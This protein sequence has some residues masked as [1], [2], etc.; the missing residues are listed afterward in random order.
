MSQQEFETYLSV[1]SRLL[2][3]APEQREHVAEELRD[4]LET[5]LE[6]LTSQGVPHAE[7]VKLALDEFGDAAGVATSFFSI[8]REQR[9]RWVM[10]MTTISVGAA[11]AVLLVSLA[12]WPETQPGPAPRRAVAQLGGAAPPFN[13]G[14]TIPGGALPG[15]SPKISPAPRKPT[16]LEEKLTKRL[17]VEFIETPLGDVL[18]FLADTNNVQ[19]YVNAK[20]L[21]EHG[22]TTDSPI[23]LRLKEVRM[24]TVLDLVLDQVSNGVAAYAERDGVLIISEATQLA[25]RLEVHVYNCRDLLSLDVPGPNAAAMMGTGMPGAAPVSTPMGSPPGL[26]TPM[27]IAGGY[28]GSG[29][30]HNVLSGFGLQHDARAKHLMM[31]VSQIVKPDSWT[32]AGG[33]GS[34]A[35]Y[36]GLLVVRQSPQA[37]REVEKLLAMLREQT[38]PAAAK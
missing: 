7:A 6:E 38:A 12:L 19:F 32:E 31:L 36:G 14:G 21:E 37:H 9:R 29:M 24:D 35:E 25:D 3:L 20:A 23:T 27:G 8:V 5:R 4:H 18:T 2:R 26:A 10:R 1:L 16:E 17:S 11:A 13:S 34:L 30:G 15:A 28:G 22:I 33:S